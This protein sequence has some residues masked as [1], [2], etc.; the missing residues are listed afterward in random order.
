[1]TCIVNVIN[2]AICLVT[3]DG[4]STD[5]IFQWA[6][7]ELGR[8]VVITVGDHGWIFVVNNHVEATMAKLRFG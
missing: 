8:S 2:E 6:R 1:M 5:D 4:V 3:V 7:A